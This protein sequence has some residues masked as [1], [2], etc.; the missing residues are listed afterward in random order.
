M[1]GRRSRKRPWHEPHRE[2][3]DGVLRGIR[4]SQAGPDGDQY[5]VQSVGPARKEYRCPGCNQPVK[6]GTPHLVV[7]KEESLL[8][9]GAGVESRRHWHK[10]CWNRG[11]R[12]P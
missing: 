10:H 2:L 9:W 12:A 4:H 6:V 5:Q 3:D 8:G 7:W 11:L 1:A